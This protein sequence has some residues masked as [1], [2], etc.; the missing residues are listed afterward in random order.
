MTTVN[1]TTGIQNLA[2]GAGGAPLSKTSADFNMFLKMLTTQMQNQDPLDPM[3]T[4]EYTQQLVQYSQVEQ[5]IQQTQT[6]RDILSRLS[7]QDMAQASAF[8]G[9]EAQFDSNVAGL[10]GSNPASW[11]YSTSR[12]VSSLVATI[13]DERGKTVDTRVLDATA[14]NGRFDWDGALPTGVKAPDGGYTLTVQGIDSNGTT[15][16]VAITSIG[17]VKEVVTGNGAVNLRVN[18]INYP[19][20]TLLRVS[21][22]G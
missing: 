10:S 16:P 1:S 21:A 17:N 6:L 9:R 14:L 20:S 12:A 4:S 11:T 3:D 8:I 15:I 13:T 22:A 18:G 7:T 19:A 2:T 5:T